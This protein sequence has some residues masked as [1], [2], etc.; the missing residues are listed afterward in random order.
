MHHVDFIHP[1]KSSESMLVLSAGFQLKEV[2]IHGHSQINANVS[3]S[4]DI[5]AHGRVATR[6]RVVFF[7]SLLLVYSSPV[8]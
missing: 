4:S 3:N 5:T 8:I 2:K 6:G 7:F 1:L